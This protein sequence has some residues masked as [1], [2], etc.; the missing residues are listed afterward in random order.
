MPVV[1]T[2][3][4]G[5]AVVE[6]H[7]PPSDRWTV[8]DP[9]LSIGVV[10]GEP[11]Y[12]LSRVA[13]GRLLDDGRIVISNG[14]SRELRV[15]DR[16]GSFERSAGGAGEGPGEF[17]FPAH[18]F[19][20]GDTLRVWDPVH[21]RFSDYRTDDLELLGV[22][23]ISRE[24]LNAEPVTLLPDGTMV[25]GSDQY[26]IPDVGFEL[27][28]TAYVRISPDGEILDSLPRQPLAEMGRLEEVQ[29]VGGPVFGFRSVTA[30]AADGYWVGIARDPELRRFDGNGTLT[31]VV[32]WSAGDRT[33]TPDHIDRYI[34]DRL[35]GASDNDQRR[36]RQLIDAQGFAEEFPV[37][38][39]LFVSTTGAVW[40]KRFVR[41]G[42]QGPEQWDVFDPD[43]THRAVA[44]LP[45]GLRILEITD[46][47]I[48][49]VVLD[50]LDVERVRIYPIETA[51]GDA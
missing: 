20:R 24:I 11:E 19:L 10:A 5:V 32:R 26:A 34:A 1:R 6:N 35:E 51:D 29:M 30:G 31:T 4:A 23:T 15:F 28:Y 25:M 12:E 8:G 49:G 2:D 7:A 36:S 44:D 21:S 37:L 13:F 38:E 41:P 3:S 9:T 22:R 45:A 39:G 50:E 48:L 46:G 27:M 18:M 43:G 33:V 47:S 16:D 17:G 14:A 40:A 42:H